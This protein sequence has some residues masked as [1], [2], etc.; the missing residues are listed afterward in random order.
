MTKRIFILFIILI[1]SVAIFGAPTW[2]IKYDMVQPDGNIKQ[3]TSIVPTEIKSLWTI[4]YLAGLWEC[5][6]MRFDREYNGELSIGCFLKK[7]DLRVS[8]SLSCDSG[9]VRDT[10]QNF[11]SINLTGD[12]NNPNTII[13]IECE[14]Q[15]DY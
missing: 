10:K 15:S 11:G 7:E 13:F 1:S 2:K 9:Y 14:E 5:K 6:I 3:I 4:P 12:S 8:F